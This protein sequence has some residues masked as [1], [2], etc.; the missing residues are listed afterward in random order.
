MEMYTVREAA[1]RLGLSQSQVKYLLSK[2]EI[3]GRKLGNQWIVLSLHY[4]R[5][6]KPKSKKGD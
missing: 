4:R 3:K 5:K 2:G 1:Q 6:R